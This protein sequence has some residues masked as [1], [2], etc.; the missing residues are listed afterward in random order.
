MKPELH[1]FSWEDFHKYSFNLAKKITFSNLKLDMIVAISRGGLVL[2]RILSDFL[3]L[4][5]FNI[6]IESYADINESKEPRVTQDIGSA[7]IRGKKILLV[8]EICDSGKTFERAVA[9]LNSVEPLQIKSA[10]L[11]LKSKST[12]TPAFYE[13]KIDKWVVFPY[14]VRETVE[15]LRGKFNVSD[16]VKLGF[17]EKIVEEIYK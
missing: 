3:D 9:Y 16:F 10:C 6:A 14:E 5:I 7:E 13:K 4:P 11:V 8:D 2:A 15:S 17:D 12:F 1:F